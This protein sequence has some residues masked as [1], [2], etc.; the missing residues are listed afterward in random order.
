MLMFQTTHTSTTKSKNNTIAS[1]NRSD[2]QSFI[3]RLETVGF[4]TMVYYL[5]ISSML[6]LPLVNINLIS[7][8]RFDCFK[9]LDKDMLSYR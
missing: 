9:L 7:I 5:T 6:K 2:K 8:I 3:I 1:I 4:L